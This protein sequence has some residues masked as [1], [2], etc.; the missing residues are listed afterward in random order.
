MILLHS[1]IAAETTYGIAN[2]HHEVLT[3]SQ[4][5]L[6]FRSVWVSPWKPWLLLHWGYTGVTS[7]VCY[8][9]LC[10]G[11][12]MVKLWLLLWLLHQP[13]ER[14]HYV[15]HDSQERIH[16]SAVPMA[17]WVSFQLFSLCL[18]YPGLSKQFQ[19]CEQD[20]QCTLDKQLP[21]IWIF[22]FSL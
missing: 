11:Y 12:I 15:C 21:L 16:V 14:L 10:C 2:M 19:Q 1:Y 7:W 9:R 8:M 5:T 20:Q 22:L 17:A 3:W 4:C 6:C 13:G 18:S